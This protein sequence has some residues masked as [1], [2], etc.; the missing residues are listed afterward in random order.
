MAT[1]FLFVDGADEAIIL[2]T[3][4]FKSRAISEPEIEKNLTGP[5]EG[6]TESLLINLSLIRRKVRT[7]ELKIKSLTFGKRTKTKAAV[8]YI[9]GIVNKK[10]IKRALQAS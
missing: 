9:D 8:C 4:G 7:N 1:P 2:N 6:F 3:K 10:L 5:R